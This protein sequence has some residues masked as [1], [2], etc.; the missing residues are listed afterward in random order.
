MLASHTE[1]VTELRHG[2]AGRGRV[3][4]SKRD[5]TSL[6][7]CLDVEPQT[8]AFEQQSGPSETTKITG[9]D[10]LRRIR[11]APF[12]TQGFDDRMR[13]EWIDDAG[14]SDPIAVDDQIAHRAEHGPL[15]FVEQTEIES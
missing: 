6:L 14:T 8:V 15:T 5:T 10:P 7:E 9:R 2:E 13:E 3:E 12:A 4:K 11:R 1:G